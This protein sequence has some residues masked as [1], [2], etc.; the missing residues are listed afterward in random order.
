MCTWSSLRASWWERWAEMA[1][2]SMLQEEVD[3]QRLAERLAMGYL[4]SKLHS[5]GNVDLHPKLGHG[6]LNP[7]YV[8]IPAKPSPSRVKIIDV[9]RG[10][11]VPAPVLAHQ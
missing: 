4:E 10:A 8:R 3:S 7:R 5:T 2:V 9:G 6:D 1:G 11:Y